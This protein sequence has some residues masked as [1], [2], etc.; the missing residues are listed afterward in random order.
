MRL[1]LILPQ[2]ILIDQPVRKVTVEAGEGYVTL[3]PRHIDYV[4]ELTPGLLS[5]V[6]P[7]DREEFLAVD[8]GILVKREDDVLVAARNAVRGPDLGKLR[9][10][11]TDQF[12]RLNERERMTRDAL[13]RLEADFVRRF[14]EL[15]D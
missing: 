13:A 8:E 3:L 10:A 2:Q 11:V 12:R 7:E 5:F 15:E 4:T 1:R 9:Q 14:M 6:T